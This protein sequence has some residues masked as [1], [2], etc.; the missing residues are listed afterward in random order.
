[1]VPCG[2]C[3]K[4]HHRLCCDTDLDASRSCAILWNLYPCP[5]GEDD[6]PDKSLLEKAMVKANAKA[7]HRT[8]AQVPNNGELLFLFSVC[9]IFMLFATSFFFFF[10]SKLLVVKLDVQD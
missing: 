6:T 4:S 10:V 9:F 3:K 2:F 1:M 7:G 8:V 5:L